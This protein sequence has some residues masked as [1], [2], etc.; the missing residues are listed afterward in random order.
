MGDIKRKIQRLE[1]DAEIEY[2]EQRDGS[3]Y[4][5]NPRELY[6]AFTL[7]YLNT[8]GSDYRGEPRPPAPQVFHAVANAK[9]REQAMT[10]ILS[11]WRE[12][13]DHCGST[14]APWSKRGR[15]ARLTGSTSLWPTRRLR[16]IDRSQDRRAEEL[17]IS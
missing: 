7:Y 4:W 14:Y 15:S 6:K 5:Y 3:Y 16:M 8:L 2:I 13:Q 1:D 12:N 9:D 17:E 11:N 10:Q